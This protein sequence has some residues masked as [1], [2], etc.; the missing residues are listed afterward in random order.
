MGFFDF[1][2]GYNWG[3]GQIRQPRKDR[4]NVVARYMLLLDDDFYVMVLDFVEDKSLIERMKSKQISRAA[5]KNEFQQRGTKI[6]RGRL[7][8]YMSKLVPSL[9]EKD[10]YL[11][12]EDGEPY[13][14]QF[15]FMFSL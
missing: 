10:F 7:M 3:A 1:L 5:L 15:G 12:I 8:E 14:V 13:E 9:N 2:H 6:E 11:D 4:V